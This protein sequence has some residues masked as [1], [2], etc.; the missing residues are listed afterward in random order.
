MPSFSW[1]RT[2]FC[3]SGLSNNCGIPTL[4]AQ[5]GFER[6]FVLVDGAVKCLQASTRHPCRIRERPRGMITVPTQSTFIAYR[7]LTTK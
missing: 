1:L 4:S 3:L 5:L 2:G 7:I 6:N